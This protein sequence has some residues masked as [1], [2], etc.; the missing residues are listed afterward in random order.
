[1]SGFLKCSAV[2]VGL[3]LT[4]CSNPVGACD[5][6]P[7]NPGNV[8]VRV[9]DQTGSPVPNVQVYIWDI[10]NCV[11][12][13]FGVGQ[14]TNQNGETLFDFMGAGNR[15]VEITVPTG[16]TAPNGISQRLEVIA[17]TTVTVQFVIARVDL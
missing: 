11:G 9:S 6:V 16:F 3:A 8:S 7:H 12:S 17:R 15:R 2:L 10:P 5:G 14:F 13:T 1:M 4:A